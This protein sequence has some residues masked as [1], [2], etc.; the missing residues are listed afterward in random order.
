MSEYG[1][2]SAT[3]RTGKGKGVARQLR[4]KGLAPAVLYGQG[5]PAISLSFDPHLFEKAKDP[6]RGYNTVF[7]LTIE[8]E[9]Q[10]AKV[11]PCMVADVQSDAVRGDLVHLDFLRLDLEAQVHRRIPVRYE[12][13][14]PGVVKGG[15]LKTFRREVKVSAKPGDLPVELVVD[16]GNLDAGDTIRI[17]DVSLPNTSFRERPD[18]PLALVEMPK[19]KKDEGEEEEKK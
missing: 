15:K 17:A 16:M 2:I 3:V 5:Q 19:A 7:N 13:R 8:E 18:S 9:G 6:A 10:E 11:V 1:N 12:G 14:P 4:A